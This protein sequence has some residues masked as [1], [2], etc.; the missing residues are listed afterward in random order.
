MALQPDS[1]QSML[2]DRLT[3][4]QKFQRRF[5]AAQARAE[6]TGDYTEYHRMLWGRLTPEQKFQ[7][8]LE[9]ARERYRNSDAYYIDMFK[10]SPGGLAVAK[11]EIAERKRRLE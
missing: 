10:D 6:K 2:W 3:P 9:A 8:R 11:H 7:R 1:Y 4:Q 5:E